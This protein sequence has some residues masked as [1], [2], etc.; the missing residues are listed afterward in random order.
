MHK[1][2]SKTPRSHPAEC[3]KDSIT[4]VVVLVLVL[5]AT[6]TSHLLYLQEQHLGAEPL[7]HLQ[8]VL[9]NWPPTSALPS[10]SPVWDCSTCFSSSSQRSPA[11]RL[12]LFSIIVSL[13]SALSLSS[14]VLFLDG[15]F[16][17]YGDF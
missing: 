1:I 6:Q 16:K 13:F 8:L 10:L 3:Q 14:V 15:F 5:V 4:L 17:F 11:L 7:A 9:P 12:V 2:S